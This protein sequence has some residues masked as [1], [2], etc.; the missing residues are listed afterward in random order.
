[1][2]TKGEVNDLMSSA[3]EDATNVQGRTRGVKVDAFKQEKEVDQFMRD[4]GIEQAEQDVEIGRATG[5]Q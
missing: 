2:Q 1:M 5:R 4:T 3:P